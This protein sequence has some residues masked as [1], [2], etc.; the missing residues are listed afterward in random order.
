LK[1]YLLLLLRNLL[2]LIFKSW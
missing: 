1:N 2:T